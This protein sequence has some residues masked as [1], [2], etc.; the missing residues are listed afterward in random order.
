MIEFLS[1]RV[2]WCGSFRAPFGCTRLVTMIGACAVAATTLAA[3]SPSAADVIRGRVT[4]DS[5]RAVVAATVIVTRGPDRA[6]EQTVTDSAGT[7]SVRF[8][9][10]TGDYLVYVSATGYRTARRRVQRQ[11]GEVTLVA[12]FRL[13]SDAALLAEIKVRGTKPVRADN[14]ANPYNPEAGSS[15]KYSDGVAGQLSPTAAGDLNATAGTMSGVTVTPNGP[16]I[17]GAGAE[18]NLTTLNG[19]GMAATSIPRAART[20]TRVTGATF[21]ATRGGF[22]GANI[23]VRLSG[24]DRFYQRRNAFVTLDP[25]QLQLTDAVGRASELRLPGDLPRRCH[26]S[27]AGWRTE[28]GGDSTVM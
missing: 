5:S 17:L 22:A 11:G 10:G 16:S 26:T 18:S 15:E 23:D 21:D 25:R 14:D 2:D 4:D 3:Q 19:M 20:E 13:A 12:D 9:P 8:E 27:R 24:G 28:D 6:I 7:Y 1:G